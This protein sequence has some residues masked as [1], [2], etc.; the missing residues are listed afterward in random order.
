[1]TCWQIVN[2]IRNTLNK[3]FHMGMMCKRYVCLACTHI[4]IFPQCRNGDK[5]L[6]DDITYTKC[7]ITCISLNSKD[8][9]YLK[10]DIYVYIHYI[11]IYYTY[12]YPYMYNCIYTLYTMANILLLLCFSIHCQNMIWVKRKTEFEAFAIRKTDKNDVERSNSIIYY[13]Y[14]FLLIFP[15][16]SLSFICLI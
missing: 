16:N 13:C 12:S 15:S 7:I 14:Y 10:V 4:F 5:I 9:I 1:M 2:I 8:D 3:N 6:L 11:K